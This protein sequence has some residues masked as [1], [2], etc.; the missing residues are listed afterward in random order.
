[1]RPTLAAGADEALDI[2]RSAAAGREPFALVVTDAQMPGRDGFGFVEQAID[3]NLL[4]GAVVMMLTSGDRFGD[5]AR[6]RELGIAAH[7]FKPIKPS[8]LLDVIVDLFGMKLPSAEELQAVPPAAARPLRVLLAEDSPV[9]QRLAVGLL[10]LHGHKT[11]VAGNGREAVAALDVPAGAECPFDLVLMDL[12]MPEMDG[13]QAT[14]AIRAREEG[15]GRHVPI[16][17][18]TAHAMKS[19]RDRCLAAGMDAYVSKPIRTRDLFAAMAEILPADA[20]A[21]AQPAAERSRPSMAATDDWPPAISGPVDWEAALAAAGGDR[22]LLAQV[23][24]AFLDESPRRLADMRRAIDVKDFPLLRRS[25]HTLKS[26]LRILGVHEAF[27]LAL[28]LEQHGA[29]GRLD[30][31]EALFADQSQRLA[32]IQEHVSAYLG[33]AGRH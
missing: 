21:G 19:D 27:E 4:G 30:G 32:A 6:C 13:L 15:T 33:A 14:A 7:L 1:M 16:I 9:N 5:L 11:T 28:S 2:L 29:E 18:L 26:S 25:A 31:A 20:G 23:S 24:A 3:G 10:E 22:G 8:E 12:Q 17:A